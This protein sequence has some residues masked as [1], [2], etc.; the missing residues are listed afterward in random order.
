MYNSYTCTWEV[1][2]KII[3]SIV[4]TITSEQ[5]EVTCSIA[6]HSCEFISYEQNGYQLNKGG[7]LQMHDEQHNYNI[8]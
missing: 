8:F 2:N 5:K 6:L 1:F 4:Q 3:T 7:R